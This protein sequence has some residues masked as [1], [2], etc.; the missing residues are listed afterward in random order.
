V[1]SYGANCCFLA[2][3]ADMSA[4]LRGRPEQANIPWRGGNVGSSCTLSFLLL[5]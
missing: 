3:E 2:R 1:R 5:R 4:A